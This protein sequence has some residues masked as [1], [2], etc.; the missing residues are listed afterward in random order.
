MS[1]V[2]G[3]SSIRIPTASKTALFT[4]GITGRSGPCPASLAPNGPSGSSP[5][6][7]MVWI[8]GVSRVV[9]LL[10]SSIEGILCTPFLKTCSSIKTS[11]RP[12]YTE[13]STWPSTRS[14]LR[15]RPMSWA[16]QISVGF[17]SPVSASTWTSTTQAEYE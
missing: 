2:T 14:G 8:S 1:G 7:R 5:S 16:I 3:I 10:Y 9:G 6:T 4:A 15:A 12:M 13:P 17:T 11:P